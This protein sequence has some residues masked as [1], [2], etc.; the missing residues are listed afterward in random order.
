MKNNVYMKSC[1][2]LLVQINIHRQKKKISK[3][4]ETETSMSK[5]KKDRRKEEKITM[6]EAPLAREKRDN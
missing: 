3:S 6:E 5:D 2:N 1:G 4:K